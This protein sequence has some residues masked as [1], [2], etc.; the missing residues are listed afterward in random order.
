MH[1]T[2]KDKHDPQWKKQQSKHDRDIKLEKSKRA[3][4]KHL[5]GPINLENV[6]EELAA[7]AHSENIDLHSQGGEKKKV[8]DT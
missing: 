8:A 4:Q 5:H 6:R 7:S 3:Q 1:A 2:L